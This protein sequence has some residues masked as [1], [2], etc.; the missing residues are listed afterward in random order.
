MKSAFPKL[1]A[2]AVTAVLACGC[3][4]VDAQRAKGD[5]SAWPN[6]KYAG[7][8]TLAGGKYKHDT[9]GASEDD[10]SAGLIALQGEICAPSGLGGG[11]AVEFMTSNDHLL[12]GQ[13]STSHAEAVDAFPHL[14]YRAGAGDSFRMPVRLGPWIHALTLDDQGSTDRLR[15][16]TLGVRLAIEPEIVLE[17]TPGFEW[18][19]FA[20]L[21]L[22]AGA[23]RINLDSTT[24]NDDF[25]SNATSVGLEVGPRF[26]WKHL[27]AG[28]SFLHR[29]VTVDESDPSNGQT[30]SGIDSTFNGLALTLGGSF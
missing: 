12:A 18:T 13:T 4:A 22:A 20:G 10:T 26:R 30:V 15:W 23:T 16:V 6:Q 29:G 1:V 19:L 14:L 28:I 11:L 8:V 21:S 27:C 3:A 25:D 5:P 17:R 7:H 2:F 9:D 24:G